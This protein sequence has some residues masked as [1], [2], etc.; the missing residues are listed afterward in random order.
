MRAGR[1]A[2][3]KASSL[4]ATGWR[5]P[6][7]QS[8]SST[9]TATRSGL[10]RSPSARR[11]SKSCRRWNRVAVSDRTRRAIRNAVLVGGFVCI[12][13]RCSR[14]PIE[15]HRLR[16]ADTPAEGGSTVIPPL[17]FIPVAE[18]LRL[19][20]KIGAWALGGSVPHRRDLAGHLTV[21]VNPSPAQF[22]AGSIS[23]I[24]A[25]ALKAAGLA[26]HRLDLEI[27]E[28]LLLATLKPSWWSCRR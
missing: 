18:K 12:T 10:S 2:S 6:E 5:R 19:I 17:V 4:G 11:I 8:S 22:L 3:S 1:P 16:G 26:A 7:M 24:V 28:T 21:A 23:N 15:P 14:C 13:S 25:A 27:T 9:R 20:D